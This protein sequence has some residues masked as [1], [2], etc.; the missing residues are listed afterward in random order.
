MSTTM[1]HETA[2]S[3]HKAL[4]SKGK[5]L[6]LNPKNGRDAAIHFELA[7]KLGLPAE[8]FSPALRA[9]GK[10]AQEYLR[11]FIT[12]AQP[13]AMMFQEIWSYLAS[14]CAPKAEETLLIRFGFDEDA[15]EID[16]DQ[17]RQMVESTK[18]VWGTR[19]IMVW[20]IEELMTLGQ[21]LWR[22]QP[23]GK[24]T[25]QAYQRGEPFEMPKIEIFD[26]RDEMASRVRDVIQTCI[27]EIHAEWPIEEKRRRD[28]P[29]INER[30]KDEYDEDSYR[31]SL[32]HAS[33][34]LSDLIPMWASILR[35]WR[36]IPEAAKEEAQRFYNAAI[37]PRLKPV[38]EAGLV[39]VLEL[40]D[41]LEMPFWTHRWHTYEVWAAIKALEALKD[42]GPQPIINDGHIA[43]DATKP[44]VIAKLSTE[45]RLYAQVQAQTDLKY[46]FAGKTA[47]RPDLRFSQND[48]ATNEETVA[49]I[50]FKQRRILKVEHVTEVLAAYS[51][52]VGLGGGVVMINYDS[53]PDVDVP[54]GCVLLGNV[55]PGKPEAVK[56]YKKSVRD[57][58]EQAKIVARTKRIF[59]L[60]DVSGSMESKYESTASQRGLM[61]LKAM[62]WIKVFRFNDGLVAGGDLTM[63]NGPIVTQGGT[64]LG[65]CANTAV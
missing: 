28:F 37:I 32:L 44:A 40:L 1:I 65:D 26:S 13:F 39:N 33:Y 63:Q 22:H 19:N 11:A 4:S 53:A 23:H 20:P 57:C 41:I 51:L 16:W 10:S 7:V 47:I 24:D 46:K 42:L 2:I 49:I 60:L 29:E 18:K 62:P 17:F 6:Q 64:E 8:G 50:E 61:R 48:P 54:V 38:T 55:H 21:M 35:N 30:V 14:H 52:G 3:L 59:V 31:Q 27:N 12:I 36:R 45:P 43:L 58:F 34:G 5:G 9:S 25:H 15:Q 56:L